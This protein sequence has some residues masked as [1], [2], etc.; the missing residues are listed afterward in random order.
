MDIG[1]YKN[2]RHRIKSRLVSLYKRKRGYFLFS[3]VLTLLDQL[4]YH[5]RSNYSEQNFI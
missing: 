4:L 1:T 5:F 3:F 2:E